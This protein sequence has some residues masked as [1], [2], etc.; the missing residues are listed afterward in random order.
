M[1]IANIY[2]A[3]FLYYPRLYYYAFPPTKTSPPI[4]TPTY[5]SIR[6]YRGT[7]STATPLTLLLI[8]STLGATIAATASASME[9]IRVYLAIAVS[10][11]IDIV[12]KRVTN[13][14]KDI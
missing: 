14:V 5:S 10:I 9:S 11:Y 8:T 6:G 4:K 3:L 12:Y 2:I 1:D 7:Y 13:M